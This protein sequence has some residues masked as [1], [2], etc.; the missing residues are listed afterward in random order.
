MWLYGAQQAVGNKVSLR[1]LMFPTTWNSR[2]LE[3]CAAYNSTCFIAFQAKFIK[4]RYKPVRA[5]NSKTVWSNLKT[6][7]IYEILIL[8]IIYNLFIYCWKETSRWYEV[9]KNIYIL[10]SNSSA[11]DFIYRYETLK[12]IWMVNFIIVLNLSEAIRLISCL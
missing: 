5:R 9:I 3:Y 11:L 4:L 7:R 2:P 12:T 10:F 1:S 8:Y 6:V